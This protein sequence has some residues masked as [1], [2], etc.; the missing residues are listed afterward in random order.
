VST[1]HET[2]TPHDHH[3]HSTHSRKNTPNSPRSQPRRS[4]AIAKSNMN[5]DSLRSIFLCASDKRRTL[6][7]HMGHASSS[8]PRMYLVDQVSSLFV[9]YEKTLRNQEQPSSLRDFSLLIALLCRKMT[10]EGH[11]TRISRGRTLDPEVGA[12]PCRSGP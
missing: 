1:V 12:M 2:L 6:V 9:R 5:T 8:A 11:E 3:A 10:F 7:E 4:E